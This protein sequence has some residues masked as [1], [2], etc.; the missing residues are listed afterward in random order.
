MHCDVIHESRFHHVNSEKGVRKFIT[1]CVWRFTAEGSPP[2]RVE[3]E[4]DSLRV[5]CV[6]QAEKW[7]R[8]SEVAC[9]I[10]KAQILRNAILSTSEQCLKEG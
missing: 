3:L 10:F 2:T 9:E 4:N 5:N 7:H 6:P 1:H 8:H